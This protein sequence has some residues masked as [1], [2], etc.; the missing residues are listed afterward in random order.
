MGKIIAFIPARSGSKGIPRKNLA[1]LGGMPLVAWSILAA[2]ESGVFDR[3][4]VSTEDEEMARICEDYGAEVP[5]LRP[6][7]LATDTS[8]IHDALGY[9]LER[10][11]KEE[12]EAP[13]FVV[14]LYPSHPFRTPSLIRDFTERLRKNFYCLET[15]ECFYWDPGHVFLVEQNRAYPIHCDY[16]GYV[17]KSTGLLVGGALVPEFLNNPKTPEEELDGYYQMYSQ[18]GVEKCKTCCFPIGMYPISNPVMLTD[19]DT[20]EDLLKA[21]EIIRS[22]SCPWIPNTADHTDTL[23]G[24]SS[25]AA[26]FQ[27]MLWLH[28]SGS[29]LPLRTKITSPYYL[30]KLIDETHSSLRGKDLWFSKNENHRHQPAAAPEAPALMLKTDIRNNNLLSAPL[31]FKGWGEHLLQNDLNSKYQVLNNKISFREQPQSIS[32]ELQDEVLPEDFLFVA[33]LRSDRYTLASSAKHVFC[34]AVWRKQDCSSFT[35]EPKSLEIVTKKP[36]LIEVAFGEL[37]DEINAVVVFW[38]SIEIPS[39][40]LITYSDHFPIPGLV[41]Y[42]FLRGYVNL[43]TK[44][45]ITGRQGFLPLHTWA[46]YGYLPAEV[47]QDCDWNPIFC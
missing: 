7:A 37:R 14:T 10:L 23:I 30:R 16:K 13:E 8:L 19:I 35:F 47:E 24:S 42:D 46:G 39:P 20:P 4:I 22:G 21:E 11:K 6:T 31:K 45:V 40:E 36:Q 27:A 43:K 5:F 29:C 3:I 9:T 41:Q 2:K 15:V 26:Q 25:K 12:I 32:V 1:V 17:C 18:N 28:S 44:Q 33:F 38:G 34:D